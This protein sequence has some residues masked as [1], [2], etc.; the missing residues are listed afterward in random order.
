MKSR[1]VNS[2]LLGTRNRAK[3]SS[4]SSEM[5]IPSEAEKGQ[6]VTAYKVGTAYKGR[7]KDATREEYSDR[8]R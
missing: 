4:L 1:D 8:D 5:S 2:S 7:G 3:S 6:K